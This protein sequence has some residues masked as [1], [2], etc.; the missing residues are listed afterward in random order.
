MARLKYIVL[1][2]I[3]SSLRKKI[4]ETKIP[5]KNVTEAMLTVVLRILYEI[6]MFLYENFRDSTFKGFAQG[7]QL[8][9]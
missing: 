9:I 5:P 4:T 6:I 3:M 7:G 8:D 1:M 2:V